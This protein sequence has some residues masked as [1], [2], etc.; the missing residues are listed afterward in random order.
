MW[1]L[2]HLEHALWARLLIY[3]FYIRDLV[4]PSLVFAVSSLWG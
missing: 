4:L 2:V 1:L 3:Q